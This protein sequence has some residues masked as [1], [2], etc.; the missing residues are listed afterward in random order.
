M[1]E[2]FVRASSPFAF[3]KAPAQQ[4]RKNRRGTRVPLTQKSLIVVPCRRDVP[5]T[6]PFETQIFWPCERLGWF[7]F[8]LVST[9]APRQESRTS[10]PYD[11]I[12]SQSATTNE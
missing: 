8:V 10:I 5:I 9:T 12:V 7:G 4:R 3:Q 2:T 6:F 11:R 1:L